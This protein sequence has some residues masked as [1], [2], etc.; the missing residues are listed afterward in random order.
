MVLQFYFSS[1]YIKNTFINY[2]EYI[3]DFTFFYVYKKKIAIARNCPNAAPSMIWFG[4]F[5]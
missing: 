3:N 4:F 5:V 1:M 2:E